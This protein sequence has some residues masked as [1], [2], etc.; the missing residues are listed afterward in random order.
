MYAPLQL[1]EEEFPMSSAAQASALELFEHHRATLERAVEASAR[2]D[3]WSPHGE[4]LKQCPEESVMGAQA[5]FEGLLNRH[6]E[7]QGP[8]AISRVGAE[9]SPYGFDLGVTYDQYDTEELL[10]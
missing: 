6:F 7:L 9:R 10:T 2:R 4:S 1:L 3:Y 5:A 8:K